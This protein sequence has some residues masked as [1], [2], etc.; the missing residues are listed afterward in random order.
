MIRHFRG[1]CLVA[2]L[3]LGA[4]ATDRQQAY[5]DAMRSAVLELREG[6]LDVASASLA[7][8]RQHAEREAQR[9]KIRQLSLLIAGAEAYDRGDRADAAVT[10]SD[11]DAPEIRRAIVAHSKALGVSIA[12]PQRD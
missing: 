7:G 8:A 6:N 12:P 1:S 4:C 11:A 2:A 9:E 5:D 3:L 10:W